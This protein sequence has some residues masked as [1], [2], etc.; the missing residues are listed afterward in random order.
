MA[1]KN[2]DSEKMHTQI[3]GLE[4]NL[5]FGTY[6]FDSKNWQ[7]SQGLY[8]ILELKPNSIRPSL[9]NMMRYV[10]DE[11]KTK[12]ESGLRKNCQLEFSITGAKGQHKRL[13]LINSLSTAGVKKIKT[14]KGIL[15]DITETHNYKLK[16]EQKIELL[17]ATNQNLQDFVYIASHDL[18]E[19]V[20]KILTFGERLA[21]KTNGMLDKEG[22]LYMEK[23]LNSG[24]NMELLLK[25]LLDFSRLSF[26]EI[27][28]EKVSL[29]NSLKEAIHEN[30]ILIEDTGATIQQTTLPVIEANAMQMKQLFSNLLHN[31]L[32]FR[33]K[34]VTPEIKI[35]LTT[36]EPNAKENPSNTP[37]CKIEIQDN[38]IGF[39]QEYSEKIFLMFQRLNARAE[40]PG[41]GVGLAI[42]KKIVENHQGKIYAKSLPDKGSVFTIL[43]P[44]KQLPHATN[45]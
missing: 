44:K 8:L 20:R 40:Y 3:P 36:L 13:R 37:F 29:T 30:E 45:A 27:K 21:S 33:N 32:K 9:S 22:S 4:K 15:M 23:L 41:S 31:A 38:G 35:S 7:W 17:N 25:D 10:N 16:L 43:L 26:D 14:S 42:C 1:K 19:P 39:E 24:K 5:G 12:I 6:F 34:N 2:P 18:R 11:D 28:L